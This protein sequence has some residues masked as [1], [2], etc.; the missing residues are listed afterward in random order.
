MLGQPA[1]DGDRRFPAGSPPAAV[2]WA[3]QMTGVSRIHGGR[4]VW[5]ALDLSLAAGTLTVVTGPNGSGKS[6]LLR[7]ASGLLRPSSGSRE[8]AGRAL[9]VRGGGGLRG[10]QTVVD[11]V[12]ATAGLAGRRGAA[13]AAVD[14]LGIRALAHRRVGTLSAGERVRAAMAAAVACRPALLCLDEP[15][16][17]LDTRGTEDL[18]AVLDALRADGR[19]VLVATHQPGALLTAADAHLEIDDGRVVLR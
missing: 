17:A 13:D 6:T 16:A 9:Y 7:M 8:C 14:L 11:A 10:A 19:T 5:A 3:L 1:T 15:T 12:A 2:P 18:A 4:A